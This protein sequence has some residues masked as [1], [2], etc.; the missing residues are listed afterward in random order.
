MPLTLVIANKSYSP[1]SLRPWLTLKVAGIP[2]DEVLILLEQLDTRERILAY[3]PAGQ[4]PVLKDGAATV[5]ESIAILEHLAE[6]FP[7]ARLWPDDPAARA[8][9][10][11]ITAEMHGG[12]PA[13][14]QCFGMNVRKTIAGRA[15]TP[16]AAADIDRIIAIWTDALARFSG[17]GGPFLFGRFSNA[18]AMYAPVVTRF[19]TYGVPAPPPVRGYMDAV[20]A[21]PAMR[22]WYAAALTEAPIAK[23]E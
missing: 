14:R 11:S 20:L 10:R 7:Y 5:W 15:P 17:D 18:D 23:Y 21:L 9:A 16:E 4:V 3:S 13:L 2:F 6:R 8:L 22:D 1:W 19:Q 12:F